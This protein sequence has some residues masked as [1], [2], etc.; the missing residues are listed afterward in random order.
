[1]RKNLFAVNCNKEISKKRAECIVELYKHAGFFKNTREVLE[2][3]E[4][5]ANASRTSRVIS[6]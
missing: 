1:M 6:P 3:H 4:P 5:Q 2:K